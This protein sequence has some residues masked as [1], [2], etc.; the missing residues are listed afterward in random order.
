MK[1]AVLALAILFISL[2]SASVSFAQ[3]QDTRPLLLR[4]PTLSRTDIAFMYGNDLWKVSRE[5]GDAIRL[6]AGPG[7]KRGPHFSPDGQWIAFTG[8]YDGKLNV[9]V[10]AASGGTPRR[11]TFDSG[12]DVVSG[13]TPDGENILFASPGDGFANNTVALFP[14]PAAGGFPVKVPLPLAWE[15]AYSADGKFLAYRPTPSPFG[16]WS[17]YRGGTSPRIWI[18]NLADSSIVKLPHE[19]WNDFNPMWVGD[20]IYFLSDRNGADALYAYDTKSKAE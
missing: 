1:K 14:V 13:W 8:E 6:T 17:H 9:Y 7:I 2:A 12:P 3:L 11:L 16:N 19:E 15:G 5:G 10:L 20:T 4:Q 18:A